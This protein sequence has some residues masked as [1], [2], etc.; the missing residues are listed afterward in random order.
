MGVVFTENKTLAK[1]SVLALLPSE[2]REQWGFSSEGCSFSTLQKAN[3]NDFWLLLITSTWE[4]TD[5]GW[6]LKKFQTNAMNG[7]LWWQLKLDVGRNPEI[8]G[9]F[10]DVLKDAPVFYLHNALEQIWCAL[11]SVCVLRSSA[12]SHSAYKVVWCR[13]S[14]LCKHFL[15]NCPG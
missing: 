11:G 10:G 13:G 4:I 8:F 5:L 15:C 1:L 2:P 14:G 12:L 7:V 9:V 3:L 6:E